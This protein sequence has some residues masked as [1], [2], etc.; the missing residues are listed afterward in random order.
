MILKRRAFYI[1]FFVT[2]FFMVWNLQVFAMDVAKAPVILKVEA[3][4]SK[5][6]TD[7]SIFKVYIEDYLADSNKVNKS[8]NKFKTKVYVYEGDKVILQPELKQYQTEI[9]LKITQNIDI[10]KRYYAQVEFYIYDPSKYSVIDSKKSK[11]V[12]FLLKTDIK[13]TQGEE[14]D[15]KDIS[16]IYLKAP[17]VHLAKYDQKKNELSLKIQEFEKTYIEV[18]KDDYFITEV[19]VFERQMNKIK[20]IEVI[21]F[22]NYEVD[23]TVHLK[24]PLTSNNEYVVVSRFFARHRG[25]RVY[26]P[27]SE[28]KIIKDKLNTQKYEPKY[29]PKHITYDVRTYLFPDENGLIQ[30]EKKITRGEVALAFFSILDQTTKSQYFT[31]NHSFKDEVPF[32]INDQIATMSS[33]KLISGYNDNTFRANDPITRAEFATLAMKL[34]GDVPVSPSNFKDVDKSFWA[35][36]F[37]DKS[38]SMG[39]MRGFS[40]GTF[41]P[42]K[43]I[44][45]AEFATVVNRITGRVGIE[46]QNRNKFPDN[47]PTQ[48]YYEEIKAAN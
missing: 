14:E 24:K 33:M 20:V 30:P 3:K 42:N 15:L 6:N 44:T 16:K 17:V 22:P 41:R 34:Y 27:Y 39:I 29:K 8:G 2:A 43:P 35:K 7:P 47:V 36:P 40:D 9:E 28:E 37:I 26:G 5:N 25:R 38:V 46:N 10:A 12:E 11:K 45:R 4:K 19:L 32:K 18:N 23:K 31:K 13:K 48:W 21:Q 1:I